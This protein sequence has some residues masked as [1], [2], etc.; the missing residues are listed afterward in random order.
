[1]ST[2][3]EERCL[4][5]RR[6]ITEFTNMN[7]FR[8]CPNVNNEHDVIRQLMPK[9]KTE[10]EMHEV[11]VFLEKGGYKISSHHSSY[12]DGVEEFRP[13]IPIIRDL[14]ERLMR[15]ESINGAHHHDFDIICK[16]C[17]DKLSRCGECGEKRV[18]LCPVCKAELVC[19]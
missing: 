13:I 19:I 1:M 2:G 17:V 16:E 12:C 10:K 14:A 4:C 7:G 3:F 5:C 18:P 8:R 15:H 6:E 9:Y 11:S